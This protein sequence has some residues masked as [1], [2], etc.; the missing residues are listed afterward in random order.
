MMID[1]KRLSSLREQY[2]VGSRIRLTE[3]KDPYHPVEPGTMGTLV[4]I[5]DIGTFHMQWDNGRSLGLVFGEDSFS[6]LPPGPAL[7]KL[8]MPMTVDHYEQSEYGDM[9]DEPYELSNY[10]AARYAD[11]INAALQKEHHPEEAS[12][13]LMAYY[14]EKDGVNQKVQSYVFTAEVRNG[15]LWGVA[16]CMV[17]GELTPEELALLKENIIGQASDGYVPKKDMCPNGMEMV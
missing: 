16:E 6:I 7:L 2:P 15:K 17:T 14:R 4:H 10:D 11:H 13:G 3:M 1:A 12:R 8:Y 5:D 9:N